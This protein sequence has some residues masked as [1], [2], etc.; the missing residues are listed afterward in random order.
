MP[1]GRATVRRRPEVVCRQ[2]C[3]GDQPG[4]HRIRVP[5]VA[6]LELVAPPHRPRDSGDRVEEPARD[7]RIAGEP[8]GPADRRAEIRD[9]PTAPA[10]NLVAKQPPP[11]DVAAPDGA[12]GD[13]APVLSVSVRRG[14]DFD[15]VAIAVELN[16]ECRVIELASWPMLARGLD[17]FEDPTVEP[18]AVTTRAQGNPI[19]IGGRCA[20]CVHG[21]LQDSPAERRSSSALSRRARADRPHNQACRGASSGPSRNV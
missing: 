7:P 11:A 6:G 19:E 5:H 2:T 10:A 9:A 14:R 4:G 18:D 1:A 16:N 13:H 15:R 17:G 8:V 3:A 20:R 21:H 12:R